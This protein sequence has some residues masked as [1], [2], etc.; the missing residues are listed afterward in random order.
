MDPQLTFLTEFETAKQ[1]GGAFEK[2]FAK[3]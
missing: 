1:K 2:L 3:S